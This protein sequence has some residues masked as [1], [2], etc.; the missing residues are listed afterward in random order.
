[1]C[2]FAS[3][4]QRVSATSIAF[5]LVSGTA[6]RQFVAYQATVE[7]ATANAMLLPIP[8]SDPGLVDLVDMSAAPSFFADLREA[9]RVRMRSM[10]KSISRPVLVQRVGSYDVSLASVEDLAAGRVHFEEGFAVDA[11]VLGLL[12]EVYPQWTILVAKLRAGKTVAHPLGYTHPVELPWGLFVPTTHVHDGAVP[13]LADWDHSL[14]WLVDDSRGAYPFD[15]RWLPS[16]ATRGLGV[17][18]VGLGRFQSAF[19]GTRLAV[20]YRA[21]GKMENADLLVA[22]AVL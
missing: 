2:I 1:M 21:S 20:A 15:A 17:E 10:T 16:N 7:T 22:H 8:V 11:A 19:T 5:G 9:T 18:R 4:V 3:S 13:E 6:L 12:I 14:Y